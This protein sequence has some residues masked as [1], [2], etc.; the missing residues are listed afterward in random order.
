M[1]KAKSLYYF[2]NYTP[3]CGSEYVGVTST[4]VDSGRS[5]QGYV[6]GG[7]VREDVAAI[8]VTYNYI[9]VQDWAKILQQFDSKYGGSFYRRVT[10]FNQVSNSWKTRTFYVGDRTTSGLHILDANGRPQGWIGA[11]LSLVEK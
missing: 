1:A 3:P 8:D 2:D 11:K 5:V 4:I 6:V 9:S 7:V 10:F